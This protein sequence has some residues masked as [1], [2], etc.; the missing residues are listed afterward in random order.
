MSTKRLQ[1]PQPVVP[2]LKQSLPCWAAEW[3]AAS[4]LR[5]SGHFLLLPAG[6]GFIEQGLL[7]RRIAIFQV[8]AKRQRLMGRVRH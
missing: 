2:E 5:A 8:S 7:A 1:L 6:S 4:Q 3:N